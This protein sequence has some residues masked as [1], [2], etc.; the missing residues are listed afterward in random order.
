MK[1]S[2][3]E[4]IKTSP[5]SVKRNN[6]LSGSKIQEIANKELDEPFPRKQNVTSRVLEQ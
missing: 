6:A 3:E 1:G 4:D 5:L 2:L